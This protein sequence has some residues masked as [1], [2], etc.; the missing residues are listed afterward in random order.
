MITL[1]AKCWLIPGMDLSGISQLNLH[2]LRALWKID[3]S[4]NIVNTQNKIFI[5]VWMLFQELQREK[6]ENRR[7]QGVLEDKDKRIADLERQVA[8]LNRVR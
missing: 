5:Y 7:L 8:M 4:F 3:F 1:I 2:K 6:D